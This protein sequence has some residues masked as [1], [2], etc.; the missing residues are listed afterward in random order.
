MPTSGPRSAPTLKALST[1]RDWSPSEKRRIVSEM[2]LPG[3]NISGLARRHGVAQSQLYQWRKVFAPD[4]TS[5][6]ASSNFL[7]VVVA[8]APPC[9]LVTPT[10]LIEIVLDGGRVVRVGTDVDVSK[11][12]AIIAAL[13][14]KV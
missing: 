12:V 3:A 1:R 14:T 4:A 6:P 9:Q 8:V 2:V 10:T 11:L 5:T 13:E 7:P